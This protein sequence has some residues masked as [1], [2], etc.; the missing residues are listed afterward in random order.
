MQQPVVERASG[1]AFWDPNGGTWEPG[2]TLEYELVQ[3]STLQRLILTEYETL[4]RTHGADDDDRWKRA[5]KEKFARGRYF[6]LD[7]HEVVHHVQWVHRGYSSYFARPGQGLGSTVA[8]EC[9]GE[10]IRSRVHTEAVSKLLQVVNDHV[11]SILF[12]IK[13]REGEHIL[14]LF[15]VDSQADMNAVA[16]VEIVNIQRL[17]SQVRVRVEQRDDIRKPE[18]MILMILPIDITNSVTSELYSHS[19]TSP[20][21]YTQYR[22]LG[23]CF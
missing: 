4:V 6:D 12:T 18:V 1:V 15:Q 2:R 19:V 13:C 20:P 11:T 7:W 5:A 16:E 22:I 17:H 9:N 8:H 10:Q 23:S 3:A 14:P 21:N